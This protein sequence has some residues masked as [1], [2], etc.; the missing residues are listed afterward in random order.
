M[1]Q[2]LPPHDTAT[3]R[4]TKYHTEIFH[5]WRSNYLINCLFCLIKSL[6]IICKTGCKS[7]SLC[8]YCPQVKGL[9]RCYFKNASLSEVLQE[10]YMHTITKI[11]PL[12]TYDVWVTVAPTFPIST[13]NIASLP[14]LKPHHRQYHFFSF[15]K[16]RVKPTDDKRFYM[17]GAVGSG[18]RMTGD[19]MYGLTLLRR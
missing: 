13:S 6:I 14:Y 10:Y 15:E 8:I 7:S 17:F 16:F 19:T 4:Q 9:L 11:V 3:R 2:K 12:F 5:R 18:L 1:V